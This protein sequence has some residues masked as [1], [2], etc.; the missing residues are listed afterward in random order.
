MTWFENFWNYPRN[1]FAC[2]LQLRMGCNL[3]FGASFN[4]QNLLLAMEQ[5]SKICAKW[6]V[7]KEY[8]LEIKSN[9]LL[10]M[11]YSCHEQM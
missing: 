7:R 8:C 4:K 1:V 2:N 11:N 9:L 10:N 5:L 3:G 6:Q